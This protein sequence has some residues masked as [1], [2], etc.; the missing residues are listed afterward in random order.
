MTI[1][2]TTQIQLAERAITPAIA[3]DPRA[4]PAQH[5]SLRELIA[6]TLRNMSDGSLRLAD[7]IDPEPRYAC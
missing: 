7:R 3:F 6:S 1:A 4:V 2:L 5:T